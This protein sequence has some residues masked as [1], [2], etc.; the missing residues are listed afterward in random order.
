MPRENYLTPPFLLSFFP[1]EEL[2]QYRLRADYLTQFGGYSHSDFVIESP[3]LSADEA[4]AVRTGLTPEQ[5]EATLEYFVACG[6]RVS[7]MTKTYHDVEA[8]TR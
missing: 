4:A 3:V 6:D 1:G 8:V 2:P 5:A 7:Q